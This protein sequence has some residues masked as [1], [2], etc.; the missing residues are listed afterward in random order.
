M[1]MNF[2]LH[3]HVVYNALQ[4]KAAAEWSFL[5]PSLAHFC[6]I[7]CIGS[8]GQWLNSGLVQCTNLK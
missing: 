7:I 6:Y 5:L 3:R 1:L 4:L 2:R 8:N